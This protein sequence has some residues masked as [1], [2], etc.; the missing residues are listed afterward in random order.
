MSQR[1]KEV[2]VLRRRT[3]LAL[4]DADRQVNERVTGELRLLVKGHLELERVALSERGELQLGVGL[5]R[6]VKAKRQVGMKVELGV[7][8]ALDGPGALRAVQERRLSCGRVESGVALAHENVDGGNTAGGVR[9]LSP[10]AV[11]LAL[12]P[13][14]QD[15][16]AK[17]AVSELRRPR[18][19]E[20]W[21]RR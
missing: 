21:Q 20:R 8:R 3:V 15:Y 1:H 10:A 12:E 16:E 4:L 6:L 2:Q 13:G 18:C 7:L 11:I 5:R 14:I 17:G 19:S 9:T